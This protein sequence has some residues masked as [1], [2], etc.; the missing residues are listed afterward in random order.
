M[1]LLL[2]I[3]LLFFGRA[4]IKAVI[5]SLSTDAPAVIA[6][7]TKGMANA[8][9]ALPSLGAMAG[10]EGINFSLENVEQ[11]KQKVGCQDDKVVTMLQLQ[12]WMKANGLF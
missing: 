1:E 11:L 12:D 4:L 2:V 3:V 7:T 6:N 8:T 5:N 9:N 10:L